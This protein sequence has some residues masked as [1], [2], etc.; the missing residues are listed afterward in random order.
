MQ[1][2][3]RTFFSVARVS[4]CNR[5]LEVKADLPAPAWCRAA[6]AAQQLGLLCYYCCILYFIMHMLDRNFLPP[7]LIG[8]PGI[9]N[10]V[11][12]ICLNKM[13]SMGEK[14]ILGHFCQLVHSF[15]FFVLF[16]LARSFL[17]F[18]LLVNYSYVQL[19]ARQVLIPSSY[20]RYAVRNV[21]PAMKDSFISITYFFCTLS[22]I[23]L[24]FFYYM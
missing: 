15:S 24:Q 13:T 6:E 8:S 18:F 4:I 19:Q 22:A 20:Q 21:L 5:Q 17:D 16:L 14:Q 23:I 7:R 1:S 12:N 2:K 9:C 10:H 11:A 3:T